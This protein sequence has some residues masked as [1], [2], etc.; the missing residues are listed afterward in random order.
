MLDSRK[1]SLL[2]LKVGVLG[3]SDRAF[4]CGSSLQ[5]TG[6]TQCTSGALLSRNSML[7]LA[8]QKA[9][10]V[11]SLKG[12]TCALSWCGTN[13]Y[14]FRLLKHGISSGRPQSVL[15]V[16]VGSREEAQVWI[17]ALS[18]VDLLHCTCCACGEAVMRGR[19]IA[20]ES[21]VGER[22][23][24]SEVCRRFMTALRG[25]G[26][27]VVAGSLS[28]ARHLGKTIN[29]CSACG[30]EVTGVNEVGRGGAGAASSQ[31]KGAASGGDG[32]LARC[33][34][35]RYDAHTTYSLSHV[36]W[37]SAAAPTAAAV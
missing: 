24:C 27:T 20:I 14:R 15:E 2:Q 16:V 12:C 32:L 6:G 35:C 8:R 29:T 26:F 30:A 7:T 3:V 17:A 36:V 9:M 10:K 28:G 33:V 18:S 5:T 21:T 13:A 11:I 37:C 1:L 19:G 25:H 23:V 31:R 34:E 4:R 22:F